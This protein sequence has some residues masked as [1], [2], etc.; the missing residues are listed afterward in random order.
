MRATTLALF[1]FVLFASLAAAQNA[2]AVPAGRHYEL[3]PIR[4]A[5]VPDFP[6]SGLIEGV[7]PARKTDI[8]MMIWLVRGE[9]HVILVDSGFYRPK[10]FQQWTVNNFVRPD[11]ALAPLGV[12]AA[13]VTDVIITHAH[14][15]HAD[16]ADLFPKAQLWIQKDEYSYYTGAAWQKDGKHGG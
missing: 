3:F 6:V 16:G 14:W 13:D 15:D 8:A 11:E 2:P 5:S 9:G 10:F 1:L 4:Y 12:H 7:D